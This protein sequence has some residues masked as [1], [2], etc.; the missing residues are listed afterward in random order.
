MF[1]ARELAH[2]TDTLVVTDPSSTQNKN[3]TPSCYRIKDILLF[4]REF[5]DKLNALRNI[6]SI[7]FEEAL[8][9]T[10]K[11][12][13][14]QQQ[15]TEVVSKAGM[16]VMR[17]KGSGSKTALASALGLVSFEHISTTFDER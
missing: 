2:G 7:R 4:F 16:A 6:V 15:L 8:A 12:S 1:A 9:N 14:T 11:S 17:G 13:L 3:A 5:A 10:G